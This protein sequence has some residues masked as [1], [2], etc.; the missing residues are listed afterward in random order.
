MVPAIIELNLS[1]Q[2]RLCWLDS[3]TGEA[4][5]SLEV[6]WSTGAAAPGG[7]PQLG[8]SGPPTRPVGDAIETRGDSWVACAVQYLEQR[9]RQGGK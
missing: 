5:A 1:G 8:W 2:H 6:W 7:V 3:H 4:L 9:P